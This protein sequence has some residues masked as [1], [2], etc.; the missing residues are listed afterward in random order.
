MNEDSS[1]IGFLLV[2]AKVAPSH[3]YTI[4]R[5]ELCSAVVAVELAEVAKEQLNLKKISTS[6]PTVRWC[7]DIY[8]QKLEDYMYM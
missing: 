5:L 1:D 8:R 4:Q 6:S 2:K 3:S 7:L